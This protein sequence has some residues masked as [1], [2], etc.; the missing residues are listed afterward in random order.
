MPG[1]ARSTQSRS[2]AQGSVITSSQKNVHLDGGTQKVLRVNS[3]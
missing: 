3:Q 1:L 2:A